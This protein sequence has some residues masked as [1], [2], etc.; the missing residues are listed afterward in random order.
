MRAPRPAAATGAL[1]STQAAHR[2]RPAVRAQAGGP[3]EAGGCAF[4]GIQ[5]QDPEFAIGPSAIPGP[6]PGPWPVDAAA[7][8]GPAGAPG[9][10][11]PQASRRVVGA[12]RLVGRAEG[13]APPA[14]LRW[15]LVS[16]IDRRPLWLS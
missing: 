6:G 3:G 2:Q 12:V 8:P 16:Y 13:H 11:R 15:H 9:T 5:A 10:R 1:R 7:A 4:P 14:A